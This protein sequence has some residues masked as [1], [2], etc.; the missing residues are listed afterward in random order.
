MF[1]LRVEDSS[2]RGRVDMVVLHGGQMFVFEFKM[3]DREDNQDAVAQQAIEQ[4]RERGYTDKYRDRN[5]P[6]HLIGVAFGRDGSPA[7]VKVVP[8]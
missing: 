1:G 7:T 8:D 6:I 2:S 4:I 3:T 5:E